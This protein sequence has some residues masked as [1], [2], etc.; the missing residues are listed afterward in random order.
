MD[1]QFNCKSIAIC[2]FG[3][4]D[5]LIMGSRRRYSRIRYCVIGLLLAAYGSAGVLGY[6]LHAVWQCKHGCVAAPHHGH[7]HHHGHV[8][9]HHQGHAHDAAS[10]GEPPDHPIILAADDCPICDL[11]VQAQTP[12]A[13]A[14]TIG[15]L[16]YQAAA[17]L[18]A[19]TSYSAPRLGE[20][21]ARGPPLI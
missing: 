10:H 14:T 7:V 6:G 17:R 13:I 19:A 12:V 2:I 3:L 15:C 5:G 1:L 8:C 18:T 9:H 16:G 21:L 4:Y 20:H 11:L